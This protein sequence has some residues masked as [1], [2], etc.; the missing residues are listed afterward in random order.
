MVRDTA[1]R[2]STQDGMCD[3]TASRK[4][5]SEHLLFAFAPLGVV[6]RDLR[7]ADQGALV[8][9]DRVDHHVRPEQRAVLAH[10]PPLRFKATLFAGAGQPL[11]RQPRFLVAGGVEARE[12][13]AYD[14]FL[15]VT[16]GALRAGIPV[17]DR[18]IRMKH[19]NGIV[20]D[21]LHK[22]PVHDVGVVDDHWMW[23]AGVSVA[24]L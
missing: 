8:V 24:C 3:T 1:S 21:T 23:R 6:A 4:L 9:M 2:T 13:P 22:V 10:A 11:L 20:D 17:G 14:F 15:R 5:D 19:I 16:L 18:A 12:V 7:E